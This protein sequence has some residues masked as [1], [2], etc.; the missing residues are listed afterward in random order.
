MLTDQDGS[1]AGIISERDIIK[2]YT[3][4]SENV[5]QLKAEELMTP[6][7]VTCTPETSLPD[8]LAMMSSY[9]IRHLPVLRERA[10]VGLISVRDVLD[11]QQ[12]MLL[13]D[14]ERREQ[15]SQVLQD[16]RDA[17]EKAFAERTKALEA[18]E[19]RYRNLIEGS[20]LGIRIEQ[21]GAELLFANDACARMF[22][23]ESTQEYLVVLS[24]P[25]K[26]IAPHDRERLLA[27]R[28]ARKEGKIA[29]N[30]YEYDALRKDGSIIPVQVFVREIIW[31][32]IPALHRTLIDISKRRIAEQRLR[33]SEMRFRVF[34]DNSPSIMYAKDR[35]H[36]LA[37]VNA[38]YL[39]FHGVREAD[40][41]GKRGGST[42]E[43]E[44]RI[45]VEELDQKVMSDGITSTSTIPMT[46]K[47]GDIRDF[48]VIKFPI[49][50]A[51]GEISGIG[52]INTDV[53]ELYKRE[54][55][56]LVAKTEAEILAEKAEAASQSKSL[57]LATMSHELRTPMN[58]VL[59]MADLLAKTDLTDVQRDFLQTIRE[60]GRALLDL[61]NDILDLSK[62]EAG[63]VEL[64]AADFSIAE[65]LAATNALWARPAQEKGLVFSIHNN[66]TDTDVVRSDRTRLRQVL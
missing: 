12:Q 33:E 60:S 54:R 24:E 42:L 8:V 28:N 51:D 29:L 10:L 23:F 1:L 2:A 38:K 18:S 21:P 35:D 62:I 46:S 6:Q 27:N 52:G 44:K 65:L 26:F 47:T 57:F 43:K 7:V 37:F 50:G 31:D 15:A 56:L 11:I 13:A 40:V 59:G 58:G 22:G 14:I 49:Y 36:K 4:G 16:D 61:L 63:R 48:L 32:G 34:F 19:S 20:E 39:E 45:K 3:K 30:E 66:V 9:R 17:L 55:E 25:G 41:I 53:T 64:E 5:D